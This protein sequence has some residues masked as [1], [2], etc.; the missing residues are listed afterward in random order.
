MKGDRDMKL[1]KT[2]HSYYCSDSN[3]YV[4]GYSNF[5]KSEYDTWSEFKEEWLLNDR[6]LEDDYN[7]PPNPYH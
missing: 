4:D 5:G 1:Q 7:H 2:N 3:Y 6:D